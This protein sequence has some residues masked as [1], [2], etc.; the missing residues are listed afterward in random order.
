MKI[1]HLHNTNTRKWQVNKQM[2]E[3]V[4]AIGPQEYGELNYNP[5]LEC[6][7]LFITQEALNRVSTLEFAQF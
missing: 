6:W 5:K 1:V 7:D 2:V 4:L 3:T